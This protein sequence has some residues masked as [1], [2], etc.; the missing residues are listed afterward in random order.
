MMCDECGVNPAIFRFVKITDNNRE[1]QNLCAA[2]MAKKRNLLSEIGGNPLDALSSLLKAPRPQETKEAEEIDPEM[3]MLTCPQCQMAYAD[4]RKGKTL[5]CSQC[6]GAFREP[7]S[8]FMNR[9]HGSSQHSGRVPGGIHNGV[10]I[11]LKIDRLKV[12]LDK[13]IANEEY[14]QAAGYRDAIRSLNA[15]L[16]AQDQEIR[17][18]PPE[19]LEERVPQGKDEN[20]E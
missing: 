3:D 19:R 7:L 2:C 8:A 4:F 17:V 13:A 10:S 5:G 12:Q 6:Y 14:E 11:R 15:Q 20:H 1:E 9:F 18:R 16:A